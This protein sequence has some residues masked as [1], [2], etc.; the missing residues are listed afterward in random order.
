MTK[1]LDKSKLVEY[2]ETRENA[3]SKLAPTQ[4]AYQVALG[5]LKSLKQEINTGEFDCEA[6]G[7]IRK[8][9]KGM[10]LHCP[11]K[12]VCTDPSRCRY[13]L[14]YCLKIKSTPMSI[15]LEQLEQELSEIKPNQP[16]KNT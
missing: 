14:K 2:I 15:P 9:A 7:E 11:G 1:E 13:W 4:V 6:G 16:V 10:K 5:I 8:I 12:M 3:I